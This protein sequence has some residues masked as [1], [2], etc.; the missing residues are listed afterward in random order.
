MHV[1]DRTLWSRSLALLKASARGE[2]RLTRSCGQPDRRSDGCAC[3]LVSNN[4]RGLR[5]G[6]V[7]K[8][9]KVSSD[10]TWPQSV[11]LHTG[12][13]SIN[14]CHVS[15]LIGS[16]TTRAAWAKTPDGDA[17]EGNRA[18]GEKIYPEF[19][20]RYNWTDRIARRGQ[21]IVSVCARTKELRRDG[22]EE[23]AERRRDFGDVPPPR[24]RPHQ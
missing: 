16:G 13:P 19:R 1:R 5:Y 18:R 11:L 7:R 14:L 23:F 22:S 9:R 8:D 17:A 15:E 20:S 2:F 21:T 3:A 10:K 24:V 6:R 12:T 4:P